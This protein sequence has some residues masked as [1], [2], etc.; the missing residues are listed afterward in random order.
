MNKMCNLFHEYL[1]MF[2]KNVMRISYLEMSLIYKVH[3]VHDS[4]MGYMI[5]AL[6][7]ICI[8]WIYGHLQICE[9]IG[10]QSLEGSG[11]TVDRYFTWNF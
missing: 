4:F 2:V 8:S 10:S 7:D 3:V 9:F 11:L 1:I 5:Q 6:L